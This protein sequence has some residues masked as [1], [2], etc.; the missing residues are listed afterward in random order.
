MNETEINKIIKKMITN[1]ERIRSVEATDDSP[2]NEYYFSYP[3]DKYTWSIL[4]DDSG[5]YRLFY[6]PSNSDRSNFL[7]FEPDNNFFGSEDNFK[8]LH[9]IVKN[10]LFGF[11]EVVKD[12]LGEF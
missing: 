10:K 3:E 6:Y 8:S 4:V 1:S 11:D 9:T 7:S 12:I 2:F 5:T